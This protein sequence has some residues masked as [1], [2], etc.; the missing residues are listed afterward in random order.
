M[1]G[2]PKIRFGTDGWRG[3][4]GEDFTFSRV[5]LLAQAIANYLS[6][7]SP[8]SSLQSVVVGY[9]TRHLSKEFAGAVARVLAR[10]GI[11]VFLSN[12]FAPTPAFSY[13]VVEKKAMGAVIITASHN[14]PQY[15]GLK[16]KSSSGGSATFEVTS[17]IEDELNS[18]QSPVSSLQS[19]TMNR[20]PSAVNRQP[21]TI[22][23]SPF[24][25]HEFDPKPA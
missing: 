6:L 7:Q 14:P 18:L 12:S 19:P 4:I 9:D 13:A 2:Q 10:N 20:Q 11:S 16:F 1:G 24:T 21:Q 15:N 3:V 25:I 23:H 22:H 5:R 8:V 17:A